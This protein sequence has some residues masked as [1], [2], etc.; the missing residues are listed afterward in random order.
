MRGSAPID[1]TVVVV[2][3]NTCAQTLRA[4]ASLPAAAAPYRLQRICVDNDSTDGTAAR[5]RA[6]APD[7][8]VI[9]NERNLGFG[10]GF[11][12]ALPTCRGRYTCVLNADALP[13]SGSLAYL[14][15]WL[16]DHGDRDLVAPQLVGPDGEPQVVARPEPGLGVFLHEATCLEALGIG[17]RAADAWHAGV[18]ATTP[19][20]VP[21]LVGACLVARTALLR[22]LGGFDERYFHFWEDTDLCRRVRRAEGSV[23]IVPGGPAVEHIGGAATPKHDG[24]TLRWF[25]EGMVHYARAGVGRRRGAALAVLLT[26]GFLLRAIWKACGLHLR[27]LSRALRGRREEARATRARA[28]LWSSVLERQGLPLLRM[29]RRTRRTARGAV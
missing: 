23:W 25:V 9:G 20:S 21:N 7:V 11:N 15:D 18:T 2:S 3:W 16:E 19:T 12:R 8:T 22:R 10:A 26:V 29:L 28:A 1:L 13:R 14:V 6:E 17:E 4:L 5:V 24:V 27:A